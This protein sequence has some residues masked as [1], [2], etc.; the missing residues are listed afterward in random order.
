[1]RFVIREIAEELV[2]VT[3]PLNYYHSIDEIF[4][5]MPLVLRKRQA[6]GGRRQAAGGRRQNGIEL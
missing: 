3:F 1:M 2:H 6:A 5:I 4:H